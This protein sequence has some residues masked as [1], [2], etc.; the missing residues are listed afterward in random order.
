MYMQQNLLASQK[1]K[2]ITSYDTIIIPFGKNMW[3]ATFCCIIAQFL[4]LVVMQNLWSYLSGTG[5]PEDFIFE[6]LSQVISTIWLQDYRATKVVRVTEFVDIKIRVACNMKSLNLLP[7][8]M[9][10]N[11]SEVNKMSIT[12]VILYITFRYISLYWTYPQ[13]KAQK[14]D[15]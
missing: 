7:S 4:L 12:F 1:P 10:Q 5:N 3:F 8:P 2:K 14:M 6:G 11:S 15:K 13:E 9:A